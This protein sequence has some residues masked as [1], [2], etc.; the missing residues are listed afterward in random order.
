MKHWLTT[1]IAL[2]A[3]TGELKTWC[4]ETV[5][6]PTFELAQEWCYLNR[7]HL[8]VIGEL[9]AEVPC[10]P[11]STTPDWDKKIDY[12]ITNKN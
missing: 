6:A 5:T 4:G 12:E 11:N 7:G 10:K 2:D 1:F 8:T 9:I 3:L